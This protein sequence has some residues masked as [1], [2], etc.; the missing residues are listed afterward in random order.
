MGSSRKGWAT[1]TSM[2]S[3]TRKYMRDRHI[4]VAVRVRVGVRV[5]V[6]VR[7]CTGGDVKSG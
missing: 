4:G 3:T 7:A 5:G 1:R 6:G 2:A